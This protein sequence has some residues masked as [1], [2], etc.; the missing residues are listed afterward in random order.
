MAA[1]YTS[2]LRTSSYRGLKTNF[3]P[4]QSRMELNIMTGKNYSLPHRRHPS[5]SDSSPYD[6]DRWW[7]REEGKE[8]KKGMKKKKKRRRHSG[9]LTPSMVAHCLRCKQTA[10]LSNFTIRCLIVQL[11]LRSCKWSSKLVCRLHL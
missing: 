4:S 11:I 3:N 8:G 9:K 2:P 5:A 7:I 1:S 10:I 6:I